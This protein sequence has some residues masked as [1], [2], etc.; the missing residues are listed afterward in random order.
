M[1]ESRE[2]DRLIFGPC[3]PTQEVPMAAKENIITNAARLRMHE[4]AICFGVSQ[5]FCA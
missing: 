4:R 2:N 3:D 1:F 5:Y